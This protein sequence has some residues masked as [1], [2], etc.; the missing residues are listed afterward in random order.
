M[1]VGYD[2]FDDPY[3]YKGTTTL[4]NKPS[5]RDLALLEAFELEITTLFAREP[6]PGGSYDPSRYRRVHRHLFQDVC[7]WAG[8]TAPCGR[9]KAYPFLLSRI[10]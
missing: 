9:P 10:Y 1:S 6:L 3:A 8:N 5:L 7:S 4:K 2:A